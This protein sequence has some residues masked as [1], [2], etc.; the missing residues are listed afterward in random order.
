MQ[1]LFDC[2]LCFVAVVNSICLTLCTKTR[3]LISVGMS[4]V[5]RQGGQA[6][7]EIPKV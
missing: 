6:K 3:T 2:R 1:H 4:A 7:G 5:V